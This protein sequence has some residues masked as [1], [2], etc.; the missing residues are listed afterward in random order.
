MLREA[1]QLAGPVLTLVGVGLSVVGTYR[2]TKPYHAYDGR[3]LVASVLRAVR[4]AVMRASTV[5][6]AEAETSA[7]IASLNREQRADSLVGIY[8]ILPA[9]SSS[10]QVRCSG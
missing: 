3:D 7:H 8:Q 10:L 2:L 4:L 1:I 9:S 5:R 6:D